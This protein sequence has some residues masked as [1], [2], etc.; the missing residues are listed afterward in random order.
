VRFPPTLSLDGFLI[1]PLPSANCSGM[2]QAVDDRNQVAVARSGTMFE[3]GAG[4]KSVSTTVQPN[5]YFE[6]LTDQI[7]S[8]AHEI[9]NPLASIKSVAEAFL[10]RGQLTVQERGW[11]E[12]VAREVLKIDARMRELLDVS[13]PRIL[14]LGQCSL[15][16]LTH[17]VVL[18]ARSH[19]KSVN[20]NGHQI[21]LRFI[22]LTTE[23]IVLVMDPARI[24]DAV[25]NLVLNAIESIEEKGRVTV[26][27][28][29]RTSTSSEVGEALIEV[30]DTGC[31]IP[32]EI[33]NKIFEPRL[34]TKPG[35]TG[36]GLAAVRH[37]AAA[38]HGRITFKTR[39]GRGSKFTLALPLR[40]QQHLTESH[41]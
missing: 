28:R 29:S 25:L 5:S 2:D 30:T 4:G 6:T 11:M 36:L 20:G 12:A 14:N 17:G 3:P 41:A 7:A 38:H 37:T 9:K 21:S 33:R 34:T 40:S 39:I 13:Q 32:G 26:C 15:N 10:E 23:P 8:I 35:G 1:E 31:G 18:L 24:E 27:L 16:E 22:D 19:L